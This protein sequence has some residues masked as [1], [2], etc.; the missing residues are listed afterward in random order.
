MH[1]GVAKVYCCI[2]IWIIQFDVPINN[3]FLVDALPV[4]KQIT[5]LGID[6]IFDH[7]SPS[8]SATAVDFFCHVHSQWL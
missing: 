3:I 5:R 4:W 7:N 2:S 8:G 1:Y 6:A